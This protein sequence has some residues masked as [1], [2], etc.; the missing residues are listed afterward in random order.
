MKDKFLTTVTLAWILLMLSSFGHPI[1]M[2]TSLIEYDSGKKSMNIEC[3]VFIDDFQNTLNRSELNP[4]NLSKEDIAEIEYFFDEFYRIVVGGK[5]LILN[6]ESSNVYG[7]NTVLSLKFSIDNLVINKG[8]ALL[9]ENKLFFSE[10]GTLQTNKM[11]I[12]IP[13]F[14]SEDYK[15]TTFYNYSVNY[16]F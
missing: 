9:I 8:D 6:Y 14:V 5:K 3:R 16:Q 10:F 4:S 15:E 1:K 13:P 2:T 7:S 11:T 12:R